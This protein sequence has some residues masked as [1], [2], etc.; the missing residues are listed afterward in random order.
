MSAAP[1]TVP[2][3]VL[4]AT[5]AGE[6]SDNLDKALASIFEQT[7]RP[8]ECVV[9]L[10]GP[11]GGDQHAVIARYRERFDEV[12]IVLVSLDTRRGLAHALNEGLKACRGEYVCRMD[13][14]DICFRDRLQCQI[15]IASRNR[16]FDC[17]VG[18]SIEFRD[19]PWNVTAIK[20]VPAHNDDI[21]RVLKWRCAITHPTM[22]IKRDSLR[23]V[24][25]YR[26]TFHLLED[27]D[28][29]IRL[30]MAGCRFYGIQRPLIYFRTSRSQMRRRGGLKYLVTEI[31]FR[32][33]YFGRGF[34]SA[35]HVIGYI[36]IACFLRLAPSAVR[37]S[38][39][40]FV[41][42]PAE[43]WASRSNPTFGTLDSRRR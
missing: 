2:V 34:F 10:D 31:R 5:Y 38:L 43:G 33:H 18:W 36:P 12:P 1:G 23:D 32:V 14:D 37:E 28:C 42:T 15:D 21:V 11:I 29:L 27:Y 22:L 13:S 20:T 7:K 26:S 6:T 35:R 3:S 17:I 16:D 24:G 25:G 8:L 9:V 4:M 30:S 39:Y 41:R 40:R 19:D